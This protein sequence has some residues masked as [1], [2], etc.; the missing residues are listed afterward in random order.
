MN[1]FVPRQTNASLLKSRYLPAID[2]DGKHISMVNIY[3]YGPCERAERNWN[4][5]LETHVFDFQFAGSSPEC[6]IIKQEFKQ[7]GS[8]KDKW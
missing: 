8:K 7:G 4:V 1:L 2:I 6:G 5:C 3:V